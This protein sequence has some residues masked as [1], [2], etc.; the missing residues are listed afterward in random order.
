[1]LQDWQV[2]IL[3]AKHQAQGLASAL[4]EHKAELTLLPLIDIVPLA[5]LPSALHAWQNALKNADFL[6]VTSANAAFCAPEELLNFISEKTVVMTMG[7]ATSQALL[8]KH[9][10]LQ[11][12]Y[13]APPGATSESILN[14]PFLQADRVKNKKVALLAGKDG[15]TVFADT[16]ANR[17][18]QIEWMIVYEQQKPDIDLAETLLSL[19]LHPKV[20]FIATSSRVLENLV[21]M[22]PPT[23][24]E[25]LLSVHL[26]V[27]SHRIYQ[28]AKDKGFKQIV[29]ADGAQTHAILQALKAYLSTTV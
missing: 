14:E 3:R 15:R 10:T 4:L 12:H 22:A 6:L 29:L 26:V 21:T 23:L 18:A 19:Q 24:V 7:Q 25:W 16:L 5:I 2:V 27:V 9:P 28:H 13:T 11:I 1:M 20:C 8:E 17:G